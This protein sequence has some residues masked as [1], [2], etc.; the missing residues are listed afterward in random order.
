MMFRGG[1]TPT[2][3]GVPPPPKPESD[4][5]DLTVNA[6]GTISYSPGFSIF[7]WADRRPKKR[8]MDG[9]WRDA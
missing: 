7:N 6:N 1:R 3:P 2:V 8:E 4:Q 9:D 5:Y